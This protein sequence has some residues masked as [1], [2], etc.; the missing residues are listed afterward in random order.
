MGRTKDSYQEIKRRACIDAVRLAGN[1][2]GLE[3]IQRDVKNPVGK[4]VAYAMKLDLEPGRYGNDKRFLDE[5]G[6]CWSIART[7]SFEQASVQR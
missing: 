7:S 2:L 4:H 3:G 1:G 6:R 5:I